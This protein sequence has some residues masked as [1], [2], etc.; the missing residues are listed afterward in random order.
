MESA[1]IFK[2]IR[3]MKASCHTMPLLQLSGCYPYKA[4]VKEETE[5]REVMP[6]KHEKL[7]TL[8]AY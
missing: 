1:H 5:Q 4:I 2:A 6:M 3:D 8:M 7:K